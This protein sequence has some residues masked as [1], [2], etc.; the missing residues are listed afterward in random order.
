MRFAL[1]ISMAAAGFFALLHSPAAAFEGVRAGLRLCGETIIPSLFPFFVLSSVLGELGAPERMA[2]PLAPLM[3]AFGVSGAGAAAL[4]MGITGGYPLGAAAAASLVERGVISRE[5]GGR[6]L[7]FCNNS[8]PAFL[9][10]AA[11]VGVFG[12][13]RAGLALYASHLMAAIACGLLLRGKFDV[14]MSTIHRS[15]PPESGA[16]TRAVTRAAQGVINVCAYVTLFS[17]LV[18]V[19][20]RAGLF[21]SLAG[22]LSGL[23]PLS[24][25]EARA[26]LTGFFELGGGIS[27]LRGCTPRR[28]SFAL[29]SAIIGWGG[30]SVQLQ[31]ASAAAGLPMARHLAARLLSALLGGLF[32]A[33]L[34]P[35]V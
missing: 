7:G 15:S 24:L 13:V 10:G 18:A 25:G 3:R 12:S 26:A 9:I 22:R 19:L 32:A 20:D 1:G 4:L 17:A 5:E 34:W 31:S 21:H 6:L 8:G 16:F 29:A 14:V 11:G 23:T 2:R 30:L 27:A 35:L 33:A 28:L